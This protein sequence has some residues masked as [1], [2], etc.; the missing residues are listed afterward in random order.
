MNG[1]GRPEPVGAAT[2]GGDTYI[3]FEINLP[4]GLML[5]EAERIGAAIAPYVERSISMAAA[6]SRR[7][8]IA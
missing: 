1:T 3:T 6:R 5:G 2:G 4:P 7:G 8:R